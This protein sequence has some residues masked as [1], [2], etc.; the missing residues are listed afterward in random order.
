MTTLGLDPQLPTIVINGQSTEVA[1]PISA[2]QGWCAQCP[3][4]QG[5]YSKMTT[6]VRRYT[7]GTILHQD[8]PYGPRSGRVKRSRREK[9][10][11]GG[12]W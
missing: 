5:C 7:G 6:A 2:V 12:L 1:G 11:S 4:Q 9:G 3:F 10:G 8:K